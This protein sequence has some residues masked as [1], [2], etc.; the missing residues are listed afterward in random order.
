M[1]QRK[2]RNP[3]FRA[4]RMGIRPTVRRSSHTTRTLGVDLRV[5]RDRQVEFDVARLVKQPSLAMVGFPSERGGSV[6]GRG[7]PWGSVDV[8]TREAPGT[9]IEIGV[10]L[11]GASALQRLAKRLVDVAGSAVLFAAA[12]PVAVLTA[13]A[14][15]LTSRGP[16]LYSQERIGKD[17]R[18]FRLLKFR[19]M[20][21]A[22]HEARGSIL[23]L[24]TATGPAFK[25]P[26]DP[27][28]T[29]VGRLIRRFSI[30]ELPQILNV[31]RGHMSLVGPRP[32]LPDEYETYGE[33]ERQRLAVTPGI[34]CI[35]QV[36]GRSDLDFDTWVEMDL[37]YIRNWTIWLDLWLLAR[38]VPAVFTGRGAY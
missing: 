3:G 17:G 28:V 31:L 10:G 18:P 14:I 37:E 5:L 23:H 16:L 27:R 35:W 7:G 38:T 20:R 19:S 1:T 24:N 2:R 29:R 25:A 9:A 32:P 36:S 26:R 6:G 22:A 4:V 34:T 12:L 8:A 21:R 11:L 33:R 13:L 30:D 15:V